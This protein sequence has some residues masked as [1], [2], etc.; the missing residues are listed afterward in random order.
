MALVAVAAV[1][2]AN[3]SWGTYH[4]ARTA[5][6]FTLKL[7]DNVSSAWDGYLVTNSGDWNNSSTSPL[8]TAVV[9]GSTTGKR[10]RATLGRVE[11]CNAKYGANGWLGLASIWA[12]GD[13]ITKGTAKVNDTYFSTATYNTP[14]WKQ[15]VMCQEV[16]HTFGLDHQDEDF[17][18]P[19]LGSCM[20]YTNNPGRDDGA[21]NNLHPNAHDFEQ[22]ETI[23]AHLDGFTTLSALKPFG[24]LASAL[25][26]G[27]RSADAEESDF[28]DAREW[29]K[30]VRHA[31]NGRSSLYARDLGKGEKLYTFVIW[32]E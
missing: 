31:K 24:A 23:Y 21:G 20:D 13:H 6:P 19:N 27:I 29:G 4:W 10:C 1:V 16:A 12:S 28:S 9:S 25:R 26:S 15:F 22:L 2:S 3:H 32:A 17:N 14:A 8:K 11:V 7:G 18:N 30:V 5:N